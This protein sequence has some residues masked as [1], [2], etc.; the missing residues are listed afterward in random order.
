MTALV[1]Q[2]KCGKK[3]GAALSLRHFFW[4]GVSA[5]VIC[6]LFFGFLFSRATPEEV[7]ESITFIVNDA[8]HQ[9]P[10][11]PKFTKY[12]VRIYRY[13]KYLVCV[14]GGLLLLRAIDYKRKV[15]CTFYI[16]ISVAVT[17]PYILYYCFIWDHVSINH[18]L[19]PFAFPGLVSYVVTKEKNRKL[20]YFWYFSL[21]K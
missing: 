2:R 8:E 14:T 20:F 18:M 15:S 21:R 4:M 13:Y 6:V 17:V 19:V 10:F 1:I 12:F 7:I 5:F 16:A 9:K 11:W 3:V